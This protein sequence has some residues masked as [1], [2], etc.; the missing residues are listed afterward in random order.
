MA[1]INISI[2]QEI[3][4]EI[5]NLSKQE[6]MTRS[7]LIR[8]AFQT[9]V[10]VLTEKKRERKK[11]KGIEKAVELQDEIRKII[12]DMDLVKDLRD[13]RDKRK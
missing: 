2:P 9:Y 12:G 1:K 3:L 11:R 10:E 4:E 7:E 6:N 5:D 13:W 8:K